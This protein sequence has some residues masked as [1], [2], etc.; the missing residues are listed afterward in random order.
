MQKEK[1]SSEHCLSEMMELKERMRRRR[2][3]YVV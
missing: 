3:R 2:R 1:S